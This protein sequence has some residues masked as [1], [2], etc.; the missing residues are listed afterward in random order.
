MSWEAFSLLFFLQ[1]NFGVAHLQIRLDE[2]A[3]S[4]DLW[5]LCRFFL[6]NGFFSEK[7]KSKTFPSWKMK[8][9]LYFSLAPEDIKK[10]L[11]FFNEM[12]IALKWK[13]NIQISAGGFQPTLVTTMKCKFLSALLEFNEDD[14]LTAFLSPRFSMNWKLFSIRHFVLNHN[15]CVID[16]LLPLDLNFSSICFNHL[17]FC[18]MNLFYLL[19]I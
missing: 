9:F 3:S 12:F 2:K 15:L 6:H 4:Y 8:I 5:L 19:L 10:V 16:F 14:D 1:K 13:R 18:F 7:R 17:E 11:S